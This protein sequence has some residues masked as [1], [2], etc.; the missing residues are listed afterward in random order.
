MKSLYKTIIKPYGSRYSNSIDV[1]GKDLILNNSIDIKDYQYVNRIGVVIEPPHH[2]PMVEKEDL[3]IVH[4]NVFRQYW[5][6][7]THLRT[8]SSDLNDG[9]F[10]VDPDSIYAY[11]RGDGWVMLHDY[12]FVK[13]EK[14]DR[15]GLILSLD[16][17]QKRIGKLFRGA[18]RH[19]REGDTVSFRP[20]SEHEY[21]IDGEKV[22]KM[23][24][25]DLTAHI[26][27]KNSTV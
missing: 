4:H 14:A 23:R 13:P 9:T 16:M 17:E 8:S 10:G 7:S 15:E 1:D 2:N 26:L 3:V 18:P 25:R 24:H 12:C 19:L 21:N 27:W 22:Y 20:Y 11:N 6:F 5:G